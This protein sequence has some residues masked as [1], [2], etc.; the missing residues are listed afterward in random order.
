MSQ[1]KRALIAVGL[2]LLVLLGWPAIMNRFG[3]KPTAAVATS[4]SSSASLPSPAAAVDDKA[5][6]LAAAAPSA[7]GAPAQQPAAV[8]PEQRVS[9]EHKGRYRVELTNYGAGLTKFELLDRKYFSRDKYRHRLVLPPG[10][11]EPV[12]ER[13]Q[14][15]GPT[16]LLG[17]YRPAFAV[18]FPSSGFALPETQVFTLAS[19]ETLPDGARK[20]AYVLE[21]A[22]LR[23]QKTYL[24]P[25]Q[26][27]EI[28][29][30][31]ELQNKKATPVS[32]HLELSLEGY[33]DPSQK[34]GSVFSEKV[35]QT[36]LLWDVAGKRRSL[37]LEPLLDGKADADDLRGNLRWIGFGSQYFLLA[38]ALP[39]GAQIGDKQGKAKADPNGALTAS[40]EFSEQ[41]LQPG[42]SVTLPIA[43]YGGPKLP[44]LLDVVTVGGQPAGLKTAID[45]TLEAIARPLLWILRQLYHLVHNWAL[46]IVLLTGLVKLLTLWP[47][48]KSMQSMKAM[49]KLK[50]QIDALKAK[51]GADQQRFNTEMMALYKKHGVNPVG[52]CLPILIQMPIYFALY[53]MLGNAVELYRVR[54]G[55][56]PDLTASD[57]YFVLP[58]ATGALMFL[59][60]K[61][62]PASPDPQQKMM[63]NLMPIMFTVFSIFLPA[64][65]TVYIMTN[66]ILGMAQQAY[67]NRDSGGKDAPQ[68]VPVAVTKRK[69]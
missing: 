19:D 4:A 37:A 42:Q 24:F 33:Q 66:T 55:W 59:Q 58:L 12:Q 62:S 26:S 50:P 43:I 36:E 45:Y 15:D 25:A 11:R 5:Q 54:L 39:Y 57:P 47:S 29:L 64:G 68:P 48:Y 23:F 3:K 20:L 2:C 40:A 44:E 7:A 31:V 32:Y 1:E 52:G 60:T 38:A 41:T 56:I 65:L 18:R 46:A 16:N 21:T 17:S 27:Y 34:P 9:I 49:G 22:E 53:S 30:S 8:V 28:G 51:C 63:A 69:K 6:A 14:G 13:S 35:P 61:L 67:M 10:S